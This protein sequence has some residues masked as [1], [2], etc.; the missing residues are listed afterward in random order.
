LQPDG[1]GGL[2]GLATLVE[3]TGATTPPLGHAPILA[4]TKVS[5][6]SSTWL[7]YLLQALTQCAC[8]PDCLLA[9]WRL[10]LPSALCSCIQ[11]AS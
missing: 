11:P 6:A 7:Q 10:Q 5:W 8:L 9:H 2:E 3:F 1:A 4:A